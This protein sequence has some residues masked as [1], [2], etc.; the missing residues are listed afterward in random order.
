MDYQKFLDNQNDQ[1]NKK[2]DTTQVKTNG[3]QR[4]FNDIGGYLVIFRH[5]LDV[6]EQIEAFTTQLSNTAPMIP[7]GSHNLHTTI[8]DYP[9]PLPDLN[10]FF[11]DKSI[12]ENLC[13]SIHISIHIS[14]GEISTPIFE[15]KNNWLYDQASILIGG[16]VSKQFTDLTQEIINRAA[17]Q[18]KIMLREPWGAHITAGRFIESRAPDQL[19]E[20]F[21]LM[22]NPPQIPRSTPKY[23][24]VGFFRLSSAGFNLTTYERF[25]I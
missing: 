24:D 2:K 22:K 14:L 19:Q 25:K 4:G 6:T 11:P 7:Y 18:K 16:H 21:E 13:T 20:F 10:Q 17:I 3:I 12:L 1:Y 5:P 8:S 9:K 15:Y 23:I